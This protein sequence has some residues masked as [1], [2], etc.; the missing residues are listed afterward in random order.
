MADLPGSFE[1]GLIVSCQPVPGGPMDT[2]ECV[3]GFAL[4]ALDGGACGLRIESVPYVRAV[5]ARTDAPIIGIVKHD[6]PDSPVRITPTLDHVRALCAEGAD[7]VAVDATRRPRPASVADLIAAI[8]A[9]G[10]IAM[11]DCSDIEDARQALECGADLVGS[12]LSGYVGDMESDEPD[13][14]LLTQMRVLTPQV[15]AE[16]RIRSPEQAAMALECGAM[17][18]VVGSAITRTEHAT[19]W[20]RAAL[21]H[22]ASAM[23]VAG[24]TE[25]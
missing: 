3:A 22:V 20:Y 16:G 2:A 7:I 13:F 17:A 8:H 15:I 14:A 18:V 23:A 1:N 12:T 19:G 6:L 5:R 25:R 9:E 4:A 10:A 21:T 11:A 24:R